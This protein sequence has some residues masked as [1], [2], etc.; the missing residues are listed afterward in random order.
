MTPSKAS[1]RVIIV[2]IYSIKNE[3]NNTRGNVHF[4]NKLN[5]LIVPT[6]IVKL[7]ITVYPQSF[8]KNYFL[9]NM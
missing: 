4:F 6:I 2:K 3:N 5:I 1:T 9:Y 7:A 8:E